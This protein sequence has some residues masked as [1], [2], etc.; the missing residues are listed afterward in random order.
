MK[1]PEERWRWRWSRRTGLT[2][3]GKKAL[4][5]NLRR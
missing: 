5:L 1:G 3:P 4:F 2:L